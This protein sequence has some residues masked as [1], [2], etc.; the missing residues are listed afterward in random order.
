M[1][2]Y[3]LNLKKKG[4]NWY[5]LCPFHGEKTPSFTINEEKGFYHCFGCGANGWTRE[6]N[7]TLKN[8]NKMKRRE[9]MPTTDTAKRQCIHPPTGEGFLFKKSDNI[10]WLKRASSTDDDDIPF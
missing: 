1:F 3:G 9:F 4:K 5:A 6:L 8:M 2:K 10:P 7:N